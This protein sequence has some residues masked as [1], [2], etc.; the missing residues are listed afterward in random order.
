MKKFLFILVPSFLLAEVS[1]DLLLDCS[2][3]DYR[4]C[5]KIGSIKMNPYSADYN[6]SKAISFLKNSCDNGHLVESCISLS[7]YYS[8][9]S[10]SDIDKYTLYLKKSCDLKDAFSCGVLHSKGGS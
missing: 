7:K 9:S 2:H 5:A 4:A 10:T 6:P 1:N 3:N 8:S